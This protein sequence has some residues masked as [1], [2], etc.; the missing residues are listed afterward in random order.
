VLFTCLGVA[1]DTRNTVIGIRSNK[2]SHFM[3]SHRLG[4]EWDLSRQ[5]LDLH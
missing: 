1:V 3:A 5:D 2:T 4:W